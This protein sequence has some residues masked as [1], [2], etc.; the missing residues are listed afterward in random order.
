MRPLLVLVNSLARTTRRY[1]LEAISAEYRVWLL[2]HT[3]P[4][5]ELPFLTGHTVVDTLDPD[6][7]LAAVTA[8][9]RAGVD[10]V[11]CW[12]EVRIEAA[13]ELATRLGLPGD[14]AAIR[15]CRDKHATRTALAAAGVP[16]ARSIAVADVEAATSAAASIGYPVVVKP[17]ALS[18]SFGVVRVDGPDALAAAFRHAA[19]QGITGVSTMDE[20]VLV[21][22]Y[23]DGP[24]ISFDTVRHRGIDSAVTLAHKQL[25]YPPYFEEVGH[26][27]AAADPLLADAALWDVVTGALDAVGLR[28]GWAHTELRFTSGGPKVVE[29]NARIGGDM[30]PYLGRMATGVDPGLLAAAVACGRQPVIT[31]TSRRVAGIRF[32]YPDEPCTVTGMEITRH[33][34]PPEVDFIEQLVKPGARIQPPPQ[35][36]VYGRFCMATVLA[37]SPQQCQNRLDALGKAITLLAEYDG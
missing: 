20:N 32:C 15:R 28:D 19:G 22:E 30:I 11:L 18:G 6:A 1:L 16:Q 5:W 2:Q 4:D 23:L 9:G 34:L 21:E 14:P 26:V 10:G 12:D 25:G 7:M 3:E 37:D 29:I 31:P 24:E 36:H 27:V 13:A 8:L 35:G 33:L 17:R